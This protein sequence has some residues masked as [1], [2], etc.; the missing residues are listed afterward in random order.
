MRAIVVLSLLVALVSQNRASF[1]LAQTSNITLVQAEQ[2][3]LLAIANA[4]P[5]LKTIDLGPWTP[6]TV[7]EACNGEV[8]GVT[9]CDASGHILGLDL[10]AGLIEG[11]APADISRLTELTVL[12]T[13]YGV[14]G[15]LPSAWKSLTKLET[16]SMPVT[17]LLGGIPSEWSSMTSLKSLKVDFHFSNTNAKSSPPSFLPQ[18]NEL[19]ISN[20]DW[21]SS[22]IPAA[23]W[24]NSEL[25]YVRMQNVQLS[26]QGFQSAFFQN[27]KIET[28]ILASLGSFSASLPSDISAMT[29]L[30]TLNLESV[31]ISGPLPTTWPSSIS[32]I[33]LVSL[34]QVNGNLPQQM[35][36]IPSLTNLRLNS[37]GSMKGPI[38][39]PSNASASILTHVIIADS[40]FDGTISN[41]F[42]R[43]ASLESITMTNLKVKGPFPNTVP[44]ATLNLF[45]A[46]TCNLALVSITRNGN[47][48]GSYPYNFTTD[49]SKL[50]SIDLSSNRLGGTMPEEISS[51]N[52]V[53]FKI[54]QNRIYGKLPSFKMS[55]VAAVTLELSGNY[56]TGSVSTAT[57]KI[58]FDRFLIGNNKLDLCGNKAAVKTSGF[59]ARMNDPMT[60]GTCIIEG[61]DPQ[62]CGC[63]GTWPISCFPKTKKDMPVNCL[64]T[65]NSHR[66]SALAT[67]FLGLSSF[68][69]VCIFI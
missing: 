59:F 20:I 63:P 45:D 31:K 30:K 3:A 6:E 1:V 17:A 10:D 51:L 37:L 40:G 68:L 42:L 11:G 64:P 13:G 5:A 67:L 43:T 53:S 46:R 35:L 22:T 41:A 34:G 65:S 48:D 49:C 60:A 12:R 14:N 24:S 32:E 8:F 55:S 66:I 23:F 18:L 69:I 21:S 33:A 58:N 62:E 26:T 2:D 47:L 36:D 57:L 56:F 61:Q 28:L 50:A 44:K 54:N 4:L 25:R 29:S 38:P 27:N 9:G 16:L 7:A 52:L 39:G 15:S 19:G